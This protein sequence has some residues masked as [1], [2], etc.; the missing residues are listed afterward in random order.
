MSNMHRWQP[1]VRRLAL[2][3]PS[4]VPA[5]VVGLSLVLAS[6]TIAGAQ[7]NLKCYKMKDSLKLK[8]TVDL[9]TPKFGVDPGCKIS[10]AKM[11]CVP[12]TTTNVAVVDQS[13]NPI[14]P[15]PTPGSDPGGRI[16]YKVTC[17]SR[18]PDQEVTDQFGARTVTSLKAT[19]VCTPT[20]REMGDAIRVFSVLNTTPGGAFG[21]RA[22]T[23]ATCASAAITQGLSCTSTVALLAYGG[24][25]DI[26]NLPANHGVPSDAPIVAAGSLVKI[27]DDWADFLDGSWDTCVGRFCDPSLPTAGGLTGEFYLTGANNDGTVDA[28]SNCSNWSST[29]GAFRLAQDVCFGAAGIDCRAGGTLGAER[30]DNTGCCG[31]TQGSKLCLCY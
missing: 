20:A 22:A 12:G 6:A 9:D 2:T 24:G 4:V 25:D 21:N 1:R 30:C 23:T 28:A 14:V 29:T 11:Y 17:P 13:G 19:F 26:A 3:V 31:F 10:T 8:G 27:A 15:K 5:V 18:A 7:D 16:C